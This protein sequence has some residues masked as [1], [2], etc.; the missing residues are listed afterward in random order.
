[1][2]NE[3]QLCILRGHDSQLL[4]RMAAAVMTTGLMLLAT[5]SG[6]QSQE[7]NLPSFSVLYTFTGGADGANPGGGGIGDLFIDEHG[8][9]YGGARFGADVSAACGNYGCG[10]LFKLDRKGRQSMLHT[11]T[12]SPDVANPFSGVIRDEG[13]GWRWRAVRRRGLQAG[14]GRQ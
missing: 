4:R 8:D 6:A 12:A 10:V 5:R 7:T 11:F 14:L 2:M 9:L 1:M 3:M 13:V